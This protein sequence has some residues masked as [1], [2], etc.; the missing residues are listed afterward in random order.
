MPSAKDCLGKSLHS[1]C[2]FVVHHELLPRIPLDSDIKLQHVLTIIPADIWVDN[3]SLVFLLLGWAIASGTLPGGLAALSKRMQHGLRAGDNNEIQVFESAV[4]DWLT[5]VS[6]LGAGG[7][8]GFDCDALRTSLRSF[9]E[10]VRPDNLAFLLGVAL[11]WMTADQHSRLSRDDGHTF[12][13]RWNQSVQGTL[14]LIS[15][16]LGCRTSVIRHHIPSAK[17]SLWASWQ[18]ADPGFFN[19]QV[20][21]ETRAVSD[22]NY[23]IS[24]VVMQVFRVKAWQGATQQMRHEAVQSLTLLAQLQ[25]EQ[26]F[27]PDQN[28]LQDVVG[29][30]TNSF[31]LTHYY[32]QNMRIVAEPRYRLLKL[33]ASLLRHVFGTDLVQRP[34][35][36]H[37]EHSKFAV[38]A[39]MGLRWFQAYRHIMTHCQQV[40]LLVSFNDFRELKELV[41]GSHA[42]PV[43]AAVWSP[44]RRLGHAF[45]TKLWKFLLQPNS[46]LLLGLTCI[47]SHWTLDCFAKCVYVI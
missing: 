2:N 38:A 42:D 16:R 32:K 35:G 40:M 47:L 22:R 43:L 28:I 15:G 9:L 24:G 4:T 17:H 25:P 34:A 10:D 7:G 5:S 27:N 26:A 23:Y 21:H 31:S 11:P 13:P 19:G 3:G 1:Y 8:V 33:D 14:E 18:Y 36:D 37:A 39:A 45:A 41:C 6:N 46:T 12:W 30:H 44:L 29:F 20:L